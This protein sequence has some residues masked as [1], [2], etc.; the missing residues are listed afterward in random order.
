ME[1]SWAGASLLSHSISGIQ[2]FG[3]SL[4]GGGSEKP[5]SNQTSVSRPSAGEKRGPRLWPP[6]SPVSIKARALTGHAGDLV[7]PDSLQLMS[8]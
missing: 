5:S 1:V 4:Q 8:L 6:C 3:E 2:S 7:K